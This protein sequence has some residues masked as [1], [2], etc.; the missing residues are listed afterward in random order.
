[1]LQPVMSRIAS[2]YS[3]NKLLPEQTITHMIYGITA[4]LNELSK[5][6]VYGIFF[7]LTHQ[8]YAYFFILLILLPLRWDSGGLH[9]KTYWGCFC[10]S[11]L[12]FMG[13]IYLPYIFTPDKS[14]LTFL[15]LLFSILS[16]SHVPYAPSFRPITDPL[17]IC[18]MRIFYILLVLIWLIILNYLSMPSLLAYSGLYTLLFQTSQLLIP[19][20]ETHV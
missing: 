5:L 11:F 2:Y 9:C 12:M 1:M 19:R 18:H 16:L 14:I 8:L 6:I 17:R 10:C 7:S 4:V 15:I 13:L 20:K 3:Q